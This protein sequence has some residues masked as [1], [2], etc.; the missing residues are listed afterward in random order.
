MKVR[1]LK[2]PSPFLLSRAVLV[3]HI[4][5]YIS[6]RNQPHRVNV[7][8]AAAGGKLDIWCYDD[9]GAKCNTSQQYGKVGFLIQRDVAMSE[10]DHITLEK[11]QIAFFRSEL[12]SEPDCRELGRH[13]STISRELKRTNKDGSYRASSAEGRYLYRRQ[14]ER[15]LDQDHRLAEFVRERLTKLDAGDHCRLAQKR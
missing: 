13:T 12:W 6:T 9:L 8:L 4:K 7:L 15:L 14:R 2:V 1:T 11:E 5:L 10:Y 3:R